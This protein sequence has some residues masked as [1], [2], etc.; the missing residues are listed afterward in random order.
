[1]ISRSSHF[2]SFFDVLSSLCLSPTPVQTI[3]SKPRAVVTIVEFRNAA[4][5]SASFGQGGTPCSAGVVK[6][7]I[8]LARSINGSTAHASCDGCNGSCYRVRIRKQ[9]IDQ[10]LRRVSLQL[11]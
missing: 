4:S 10:V 6:T 11:L 9:L 8:Y 3:L 1:M 2:F 5:L 7:P